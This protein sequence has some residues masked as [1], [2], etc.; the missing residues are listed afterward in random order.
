MPTLTFRIVESDEAASLSPHAIW[1][2][3]R[4]R[5]LWD[6]RPY[7]GILEF[8][9][10]LLFVTG[11]HSNLRLTLIGL[12]PIVALAPLH[13]YSNQRDST[14]FMTRTRSHLAV[15]IPLTCL[16]PAIQIYLLFYP[17]F[18]ADPD[19]CPYDD[20]E[21]WV[22]TTILLWLTLP[23]LVF[24]LFVLYR[25][26]HNPRKEPTL[27]ELP[28]PINVGENDGRRTW[29]DANVADG[30]EDD[31]PEEEGKVRLA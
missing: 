2:H 31:S 26:S 14:H 12:F 19:W 16:I 29:I 23:I 13:W 24:T 9:F 27:K 7:Y 21:L 22:F 15:L 18:C 3:F 30:L 4:K 20:E 25:T 11:L 1:N 17:V 10:L 5:I 8:I 28:S 6:H